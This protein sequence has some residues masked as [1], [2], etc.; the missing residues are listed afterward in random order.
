[1]QEG[2]YPRTSLSR[3][4]IR[5]RLT[6]SVTNRS[7]NFRL[8]EKDFDD[9][10]LEKIYEVPA[11]IEVVK[12]PSEQSEQIEAN[13]SQ[14]Q[15]VMK[16]KNQARKAFSKT[17]LGRTSIQDLVDF[18][19]EGNDNVEDI[20][21]LYLECRPVDEMGSK[22]ENDENCQSTTRTQPKVFDMGKLGSQLNL[23]MS[24]PLTSPS[25]LKSPSSSK[26]VCKRVSF[27]AIPAHL[28][29]PALTA[30]Q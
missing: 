22:I 19:K 23:T 14:I 29:A 5:I 11:A 10:V 27:N 7:K 26:S 17:E 15:C 12:W 6:N 20:I 30:N 8:T 4:C 1:M 9:S 2:E 18:Q 3:Q 25:I 24:S 13:S 28:A 21:Q 16:L